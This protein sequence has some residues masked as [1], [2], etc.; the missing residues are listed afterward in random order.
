MCKSTL[1]PI[2]PH[3]PESL[4]HFDATH[5]EYGYDAEGRKCFRMDGCI[6]DAVLAVWAAGF[7]TLGCCC[8]HGS[9]HGVI[10]LDLGLYERTDGPELLLRHHCSLC[11]QLHELQEET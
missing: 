8:G 2:P 7:K 11:G 6:V 4:E 5:P 3:L 9:G 10:S 1:V